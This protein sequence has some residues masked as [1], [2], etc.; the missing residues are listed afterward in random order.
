MKPSPYFL[1]L[2]LLLAPAAMA[3]DPAAPPT[4]R[5]DAVAEWT[6]DG[7]E[8]I[9]AKGLDVAYARP[10]VDLAQYTRVRI[11]PITVAFRRNWDRDA[12]GPG[13]RVRREDAQRIRDSLAAV[14]REEFAKALTAGGYT[15]AD[16][17]D[18]GVLEVGIAITELYLAAPDVPSVGRREV[19]AVSAGEMTLVAE[20]RDAPSGEV[21]MRI[22]D[23][24]RARETFRPE[25]IFQFD[26]EVEARRVAGQWAAA[27]RAVLDA[28]RAR[29]AK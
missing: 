18:D 28:A 3:Q 6:A 5:R 23:H 11:A 22:Y 7:L 16:T 24:G 13:Q 17:A 19:Y 27:L 9:Q 20:L 8:R 29:T 2:G 10:G 15:I 4:S 21:A 12:L 1:V 25:R 14:V 26:N